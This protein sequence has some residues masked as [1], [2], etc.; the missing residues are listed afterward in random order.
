MHFNIMNKMGKL[1]AKV[2]GA[3]LERAQMALDKHNRL[4]DGAKLSKK[5]REES[6]KSE[7]AWAGKIRW[8]SE[9]VSAG[10]D[11]YYQVKSNLEETKRVDNFRCAHPDVSVSE[12][13]KIVR[14]MLEKGSASK[15]GVQSRATVTSG[16]DA[17]A[18]K[19][20]NDLKSRLG[21]LLKKSAQAAGGNTPSQNGQGGKRKG[22]GKYA[23]ACWH[24]GSKNHPISKCPV[25]K[26]GKPPI[27][28]ARFFKKRG[29]NE[30]EDDQ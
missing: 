30:G 5:E 29:S 17:S 11:S 23:F 13:R 27:K 26:A 4:V 22:N 20:I 14:Q 19:E 18:R 28:G 3:R 7:C 6:I 16:K 25:Q 1:A 8:F 12:A 2:A 9:I 24:C 15:V 21:I 10:E